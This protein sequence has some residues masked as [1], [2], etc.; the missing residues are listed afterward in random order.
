MSHK[1]IKQ[2]KYGYYF[3]P[4]SQAERPVSQI[5]ND[6][7]VFRP[8]VLNY[9]CDNVRNKDVIVVGTYFGSF[10]PAIA[11]STFGRVHAFEACKLNYGCSAATLELNNIGN[12]ELVNKAVWSV[13][14]HTTVVYK[15]GDALLGGAVYTTSE[16]VAME[17]S[18][19][20]SCIKL[21]SLDLT[22]SGKQIL[23]YITVNNEA[24]MRI[25]HGAN[26]F[27]IKYSPQIVISQFEPTATTEY[28]STIG[29]NT[30]ASFQEEG[31]NVYK[32]LTL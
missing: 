7:N 8:D 9:L 6:G 24:V 5:I 2:N 22:T 27:L 26:E 15:E 3:V 29:Y 31:T 28:L 23:L 18:R 19:Q 10:L 25:L 20:V 30:V 14:G 13:D 12:V 11:R 17:N 4:T 21:D 32:R 1:F 16:L